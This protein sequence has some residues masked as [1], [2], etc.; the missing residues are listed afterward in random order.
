M[1]EIRRKYRKTNITKTRFNGLSTKKKINGLL[2]NKRYT[3][4]KKLNIHKNLD[5]EK[6]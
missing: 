4:G 1:Q 6:H 2:F 5:R 3:A